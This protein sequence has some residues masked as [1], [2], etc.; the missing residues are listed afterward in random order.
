M[1]IGD[2]K[3]M[4]FFVMTPTTLVSFCDEKAADID[5]DG[6][7]LGSATSGPMDLSEPDRGVLLELVDV[8]NI[9]VVPDDPK[10]VRISVAPTS[11]F[12]KNHGPSLLLDCHN[13]EVAYGWV[14]ALQQQ[15]ARAPTILRTVKETDERDKASS[16]TA[17]SKGSSTGSS[18]SLLKGFFSKS[19]SNAASTP[20]PSAAVDYTAVI[21]W[22][23]DLSVKK[24]AQLL[25]DDS[26]FPAVVRYG[27]LTK[28]NKSGIRTGTQVEKDRLFVL[29]P[30][31]LA[32]FPDQA[33][34][35][36]VDGYLHGEAKGERISG[37]FTKSGAR[38]PLESVCAVTFGL[39]DGSEA[40]WTR[41]EA[42]EVTRRVSRPAVA[43]GSPDLPAAGEP[44]APSTAPDPV[45]GVT[46]KLA[47]LRTKMGSGTA[48][49]TV[50]EAAK[51]QASKL[52]TTYF[53]ID[54]GEYMLQVN[55]HS[56]L[57]SVEWVNDIKKWVTWQKK[58]VDAQ[59]LG[60]CV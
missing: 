56:A 58:Q 34:A 12:T 36:I 18:R 8:S 57:N 25:N 45:E 28:R 35:K 59:L 40:G 46:S 52:R 51:A 48:S 32:F 31:F 44:T 5:D 38:L 23:S 33:S 43:F 54:F 10:S 6:F 15:I 29:T 14:E 55:A 21:P 4:R 27:W 50:D 16:K 60:K 24:N 42:G 41:P 22:D 53:E 11:A 20:E 49:A 17:I 30:Y 3:K 13:Q 19:E 2:L 26:G 9:T 37:L 1:G 47:A 7:M 39:K